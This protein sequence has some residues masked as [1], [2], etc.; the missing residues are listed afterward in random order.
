MAPETLVSA[1][2][3]KLVRSLFIYSLLRLTRL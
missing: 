3:A 2:T 1:L